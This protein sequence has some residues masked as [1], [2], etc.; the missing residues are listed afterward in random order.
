MSGMNDLLSQ[1]TLE[2]LQV[3]ALPAASYLCKIV[4][5]AVMGAF[6]KA[7]PAKGVGNR[8]NLF[9]VP[10]IEIV[11]VR[12]SGDPE[13]D[14]EILG[15]LTRFGDWKGYKRR[16]TQNQE[17]PGFNS[18]VECAGVSNI[19][20]QLA[21]TSERWENVVQFSRGL[22]RFYTATDRNGE[23]GGWV[24][25]TLSADPETFEHLDLPPQD[26][27]N[28]LAKVVEAT[29]GSYLLVDLGMEVDPKGE[30]PDKL[31]VD[32]TGPV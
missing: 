22:P 13:L 12:P 28:P 27:P 19:N 5:A 11:D 2:D 7:N 25:H 16:W 29:V 8:W 18:K 10:T 17:V 9:Y 26:D 20:F 4:D 6:W 24:W 21:E 32:N 14:E 15:Q 30:Y 31:I 23:R 1:A 3:K